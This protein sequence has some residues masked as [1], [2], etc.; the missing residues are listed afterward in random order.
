MFDHYDSRLIFSSPPVKALFFEFL[1]D[2]CSGRLMFPATSVSISDVLWQE[3]DV[4][5]H[6]RTYFGKV[7]DV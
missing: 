2:E 5:N 7:G 6:S 4:N 1:P 3:D